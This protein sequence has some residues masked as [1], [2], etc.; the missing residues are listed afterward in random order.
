[1][2]EKVNEFVRLHEAMQEKL[3]TAS[4]SR[5]IQIFTLLPDKWSRKYCSEYF[6]T[7]E[8]FVWNAGE[9]K[10]V[11]W[12]LAKPVFRKGKTITNETLHLVRSVYENDNFSM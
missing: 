6:N 2:T 10:K 11:G 1:M 9:I 4:Y 5:Q 3:K 12:I 8:Y 7:F